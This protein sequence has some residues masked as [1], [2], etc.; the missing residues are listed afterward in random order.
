MVHCTAPVEAKNQALWQVDW[1]TDGVDLFEIN[2]A[3]A[4]V[5]MAAHARPQDPA[6]QGQHPRWRCALGHRDRRR[7]ARAM[8]TLIGAL[9][10]TGGERG[11]ASSVH[12]RR[13]RPPRWG[14]E[15]I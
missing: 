5:P 7:A 8:A 11:V 13:R 14:L 10:K 2:E 15:I 9:R 12:R 3:F 6:R 4:V 1:T